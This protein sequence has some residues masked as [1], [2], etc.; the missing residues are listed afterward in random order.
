MVSGH[1]LYEL[2]RLPS[3]NNHMQASLACDRI[4]GI[5]GL[6]TDADRLGLCADYAFANR[7]DLSYACTTEA[8]VANGHTAILTMV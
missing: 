7:I 3:A 2:L 8:L 6:A 4:Y 1:T 5:L